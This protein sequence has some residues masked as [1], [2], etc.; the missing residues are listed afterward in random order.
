MKPRSTP[1]LAALVSALALGLTQV[2]PVRAADAAPK[3]EEKPS[4][5]CA[6]SSRRRSGSAANPCAGN[7]CAG[8]SRRRRGGDDAQNP[9]AGGKR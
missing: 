8:S 5:P 4:N 1:T 3:A 7:P 9:C 2:T 6:G